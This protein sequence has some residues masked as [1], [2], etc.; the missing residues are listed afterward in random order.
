MK[1]IIKR[2]GE[3]ILLALVSIIVLF[4]IIEAVMKVFYPQAIDLG[5]R[6]NR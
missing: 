5:Q 4:L 6:S 1:K 3:N 2:V